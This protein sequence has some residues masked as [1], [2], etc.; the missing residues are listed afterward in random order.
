MN[1]NTA[2]LI[3]PY[4][5]AFKKW[6]KYRKDYGA[7]TSWRRVIESSDSS[8]SLMLSSS[9]IRREPGTRILLKQEPKQFPI[10]I[11]YLHRVTCDPSIWQDAAS[12][13]EYWIEQLYEPCSQIYSAP[14]WSAVIK[15]YSYT[16]VLA[17]ILR[18][19]SSGGEIVQR[20]IYVF[21]E[22]WISATQL[23]SPPS[24]GFFLCKWLTMAS[25][26]E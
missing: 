18:S 5:Y 9:F 22:E 6:G 4:I 24:P 26:L 11:S 15:L 8:Q 14:V 10:I 2:P 17:Y 13:L 12:S 19:F 25:E 21:Q 20:Y 7:N 1:H 23:A 3:Q 16:P